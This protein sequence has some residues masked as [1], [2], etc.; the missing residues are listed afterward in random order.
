M[1]RRHL[2]DIGPGHVG[3]VFHQVD[4][5]WNIEHA[6]CRMTKGGSL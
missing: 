2:S 3:C 1:S 4:P 5:Q 6:A